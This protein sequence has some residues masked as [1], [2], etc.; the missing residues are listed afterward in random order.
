LKET[1][2]DYKGAEEDYETA[3]NILCKPRAFSV[4]RI[5]EN[6]ERIKKLN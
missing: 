3:I 1:K 4:Q 5:K 6:L 2:A